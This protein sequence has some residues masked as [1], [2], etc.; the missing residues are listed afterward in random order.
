MKRMINKYMRD[1]DPSPSLGMTVQ[2]RGNKGSDGG[3]LG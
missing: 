3:S 2:I 1:R